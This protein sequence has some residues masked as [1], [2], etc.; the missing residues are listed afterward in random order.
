MVEETCV[1]CTLGWLW[2]ST[3]FE[4]QVTCWCGE[5]DWEYYAKCCLIRS[6]WMCRCGSQQK[7]KKQIYYHCWRRKNAVNKFSILITDLH[8]CVC[9]AQA[10]LLFLLQWNSLGV[11]TF[12]L[13]FANFISEKLLP[14][15]PTRFI[16]F[17]LAT[18][19]T[20]ASKNETSL[21]KYTV[22][23]LR[24]QLIKCSCKIQG[25]NYA[26]ADV[27]WNVFDWII[28]F[29]IIPSLVSF[30][31]SGFANLAVPCIMLILNPLIPK[32]NT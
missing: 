26:I 17:L 32:V 27:P 10:F 1:R 19:F 24:L 8:K 16:D 14:S 2:Y 9:C 12:V 23:L 31:V 29:V 11:V 30:W 22:M 15:A 25:R 20:N 18:V 21:P 5:L 4:S 13:V 7:K 28:V 3:I 6:Q